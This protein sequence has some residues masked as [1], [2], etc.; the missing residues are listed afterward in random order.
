MRVKILNVKNV[1]GKKYEANWYSDMQDV[2]T[3]HGL[4]IDNA[5]YSKFKKG[6]NWEQEIGNYVE[7]HINTDRLGHKWINFRKNLSNSKRELRLE[8]GREYSE[9]ELNIIF[10]FEYEGRAGIKKVAS[11]D[12]VLFSNDTNNPYTDRCDGD[13]FDYEGQNTGPG[14]Q[15]LIFGNKDL[16]DIYANGNDKNI[17]VFKNYIYAGKYIITSEPYQEDRVDKN[18]RKSKSWRFPL[19][20]I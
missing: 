3:D 20:K 17:Y 6:H 8:E 12:I 19:L 10:D 2:E 14:D 5:T 4:F 9:H 1:K 7:A 15:E 13:I 16:Y 18:G 11:G